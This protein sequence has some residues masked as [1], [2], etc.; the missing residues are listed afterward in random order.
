[1]QSAAIALLR[2]RDFRRLYAAVAISELGDAFHYIALMWIALVKGGPLGVAAVRLADSIPAIVFGFHGGIVADRWNRKR[3]MVSADLV[4]GIILV[5]VAIAAIEDR[6]PLW[7]LIVAAFV[8]ETATSYFVP[9]YGAMV[10]ALVDRGNVQEANGLLSA[11]TNAL[12]IGG[13]AATAAL[14]AIMPIGGFFALNSLSF[15]LS[16]VFIATVRYDSAGPS[17]QTERPSLREAFSALRPLPILAASVIVL[18]GAQTISAGTWIAGVPEMVRT[19]FHRGP[20]GYSMVMVGWAVG[21]IAVGAILARYPVEQKT[22]ASILIWILYLP[23]FGLFAV[24]HSLALAILGAIVAGFAGTGAMIL[25]SSAAQE[26]VSDN[27]LGRVMGLIALVGRGSHATGLLF[28]SPLFAIFA[29]NA[30][31]GAAALAIPLIAVLGAWRATAAEKQR[32][33][34]SAAAKLTSR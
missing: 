31:F 24:G 27:V 2:R 32:W 21:A 18:A 3:T 16:A 13:W 17:L 33:I 4:R 11:T 28:I 10:P 30:L 34:A 6:L 22:R 23:A 12:S 8:L 1:M 29:P 14:L 25:L 5:P 20:A 7:G 19:T 15:F 9:A 26:S